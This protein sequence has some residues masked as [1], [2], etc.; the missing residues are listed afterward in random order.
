MECEQQE[1]QQKSNKKKKKFDRILK[2]DE[3]KRELIRN[4]FENTRKMKK[5]DPT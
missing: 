3:Y 2:R 4:L 1:N 5:I